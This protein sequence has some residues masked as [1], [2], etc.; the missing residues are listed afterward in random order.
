MLKAINDIEKKIG[1]N[2]SNVQK[3]LLTTDGS[4]TRIL[5]VLTKKP[6]VI[7]TKIKTSMKAD[8]D[9][10]RNLKIK[11]GE[12]VN[13][14]VVHLKNPDDRALIFARSWTPMIGLSE[15][16][17]RDLT[18]ADIPIGKI[19]IKHKIETRRE[20]TSIEIVNAD[21]EIADAFNVKFG[22]LMLSRYYNI[23]HGAKILIRIN[24][25]FPIS[26]FL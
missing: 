19:L 22:D 3:I 4:V 21:D 5:E 1:F 17:K 10:A 8:E 2:L 26:S 13:Y 11:S 15:N 23:I 24:E 7:K 6:V 16:V 25:I 20:I 12:I 9:L 14:R 18:S